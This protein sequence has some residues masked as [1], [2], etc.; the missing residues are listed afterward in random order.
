[1]ATVA[2][3]TSPNPLTETDMNVLRVLLDQAGRVT[4]RETLNRLAGFD[5]TGARRADVAL[6]AIRRALGDDSVRTVRRRGWI[7]TDSGVKSAEKLV[8]QQVDI[9]S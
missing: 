5:G 4:S 8:G 3:T 1:M 9:R 7:L 2:P 6:V